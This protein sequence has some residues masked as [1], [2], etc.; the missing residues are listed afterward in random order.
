MSSKKP[1]SNNKPGFSLFENPW[2]KLISALTGIV[3]V[4]GLGY[5]IGQFKKEIDFKVEKLELLQTYQ[6]K[7]Q[8]EINDCKEAKYLEQ[9]KSIEDLKTIVKELQKRNEK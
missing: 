7:L 6:E 3:F 4:F 9:K 1:S 8:K 5:G 2:A